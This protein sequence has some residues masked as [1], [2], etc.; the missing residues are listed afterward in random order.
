MTMGII[1]RQSIRGTIVTY[2]G[3]FVGFLTTFFVLTR[4]LTAEE[5]GL[6]RV[7]I[8][9]ATLLCGLMQLGTSSSIIRFFP[10]FKTQEEDAEDHSKNGFFFWTIVVPFVGFLIFCLLYWALHVPISNLFAEKSQL[11]VDYYY[12]VLPLAFFMLYQTI[13]ETNANVLMRIVIPRMTRELLLRLFL[14]ANYLLYA[15]RIIS[16]DGMV[17]GLCLSYGLAALCNIIY[18]FA[19]GHISLRPDFKFVNKSLARKYFSYTVFQITAAIAT[20]LTPFVSEAFITAQLGL[21]H[22]GVFSIAIYIAAMVSIPNRSLN[23]IA[24]PQLAQATKESNIHGL[25]TLLKQV[26]NNSLLVGG[27]ILTLIWVNIDLIYTI[28]P[29]GEQYA[30]AKYVVLMLGLT[31]LFLAAFNATLSVLNYS[32]YY[33]LSLFYSFI[34]TGASLYFNNWLVPLWGIDGAAMANLLSYTIY[35]LLLVG[36]VRLLCNVS[37]LSLSQLRSVGL[38]LLVMA[39]CGIIDYVFTRI[40]AGDIYIWIASLIKSSIWLVAAYWAYRANLSPEISQLIRCK[41]QKKA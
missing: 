36:S 10:Y 40:G 32:R 29:N 24:N 15:F 26:S 38:M 18:L 31:Q 14:L 22:T 1:A 27:L 37:P 39:I 34:L 8:D 30:A 4:F 23:A 5:I 7:L 16:L 12:L 19:Y 6:A 9:V 33:Y 2:M 35:F 21:T 17:I 13:F 20:V 11:F 28:L 41:L 25:G 3:V